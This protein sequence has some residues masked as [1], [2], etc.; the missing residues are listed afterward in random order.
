MSRENEKAIAEREAVQWMIDE[1]EAV[2]TIKNTERDRF[3]CLKKQ[4]HERLSLNPGQVCQLKRMYE[5]FT[6]C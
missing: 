4:F 2:I 5:K 1:L 3:D 6:D